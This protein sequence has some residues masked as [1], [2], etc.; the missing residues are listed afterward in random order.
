MTRNPFYY[1]VLPLDAPFCGRSRELEILCSYARSN[2]NA[3]LYSPRRYG[4]TSLIKRVQDVLE[5]EKFITL[6]IDISGATSAEDVAA[7]IARDIFRFVDQNGPLLKKALSLIKN[8]RPNFTPQPDGSVA[9]SVQPASQKTGLAFLEETLEG[10]DRFLADNPQQTN[11]VLDEFQEVADLRN[12]D[13]IEALLRK[14]IQHQS[15]CSWFFLGSRRRMLLDMFE[16]ESRP[17]YRSS[18]SM[19]L[20]PLP[21]EE[22]IRFVI[23]RFKAGDKECPRDIASRIIKLT[24]AYPFYV[25]RLSGEI[26][27]LARK[28]EIGEQEFEEGIRQMLEQEER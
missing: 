20:P 9:V 19:Q 27:T 5:Q 21:E 12:S 23:E 22:A 16:K 24:Q 26:F 1:T 10:L 14:H 17:F 2:T 3:V 11:I 13:Q 25:Q 18:V 8:W 6:Y 28:E 7:F 15:N 4:K